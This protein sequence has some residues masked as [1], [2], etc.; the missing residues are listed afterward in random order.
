MGM[1]RPGN[2]FFLSGLFV[3]AGLMHFVIPGRYASIMPPWM[4]YQ[5][6]AVY[7]SGV[8]EIA[9]GLGILI[10]SLRRA[11]GLGLIALLI[12]VFPANIQ[13]LVNSMG[14]HTS[15]AYQILLWLRLALQPLLIVWVWRTTMRDLSQLPRTNL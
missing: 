13:M 6:E 9:G 2:L 15:T 3:F 1:N 11:A 8:C 7:L 4:P 10:P 12:A 14:S 5:M